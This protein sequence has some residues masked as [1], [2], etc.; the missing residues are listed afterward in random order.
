MTDSAACGAQDWAYDDNDEPFIYG[1]CEL[2][3]GHIGTWHLQRTPSGNVWA[4]W[5]G[6]ADS[7]A[8]EGARDGFK[9]SGPHD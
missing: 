9:G 6:P 7:R 4:N 2:P 8:P 1:T 5:R 3:S